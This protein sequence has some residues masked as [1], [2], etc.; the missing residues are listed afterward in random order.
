MKKNIIL[1]AVLLVLGVAAWLVYAKQSTNTIESSDVADFA[2]EDTA[3][4]N[5]IIITD[6]LG[7]R[8]KIERI[9]GNKLWKLNDKYF[10]REDAV[11]LLLKTFNRIRIRGNVSDKARENMMKLLVTSSKKV[12][13]YTGGKEPAKIYYV[14]AATPDHTGTHMLLEIPGVGRSKDPYITHM[15]GF[16]G[17]LTTRF[18]TSEMEWRYTGIFEYPNLEF[19]RIR[20]VNHI[21]PSESFEVKYGGN[22]D[23]RLFDGYDAASTSFS[24]EESSFDTLAVKQFML[25]FKKVHVESFNTLLD[26]EKQNAILSSTPTFTISVEENSGAI[27]SIDLYLRPA[28][29]TTYDENGNVNPWDVGHY[30]ARTK[31]NELA[32][33]QTFNFGPMVNAVG[34]Y[35]K[36]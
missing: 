14:G 35:L 8:A 29:T 17:F 13:I 6:Q 27:N 16:S 28:T 32:I 18:F 31:D 15:D 2:I 25:L 12:E 23:I 5:K 26:A 20:V 3:S 21:L 7:V 9:P 4:I 36:R 11:S 10:A 30:W 24:K 33:A 1:F 22:N 19:K 34:F